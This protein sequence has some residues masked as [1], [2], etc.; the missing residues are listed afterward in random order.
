VVGDGPELAAARR[1]AGPYAG[2]AIEFAGRVP[3][4]QVP[5]EVARADVIA[6]TSYGW[7]NQPMTVVEA[8]TAGRPVLYCDPALTEGLVGLDGR[9]G[10]GLLNRPDPEALGDRLAALALDRAPVSVAARATARAAAVFSPEAFC[11][12]LAG[13]FARITDAG[14]VT[15]AGRVAA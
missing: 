13:A 5:T 4:D 8:V 10:P 1:A 6:L 2:G 12:G 7:D 3:H 9:P 15:D 11:G 14:P